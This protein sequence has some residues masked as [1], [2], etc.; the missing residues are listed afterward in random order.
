M[1]PVA[2]PGPD[3]R[4]LRRRLHQIP[5]IGLDLPLTQAV[6]L[7]ALS[8]LDLEVTTGKALSSVVAVLPSCSTVTVAVISFGSIE[9][10]SFISR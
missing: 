5:E 3:L 8:G 4:S 9:L 1:D 10:P 2:S 7:E 6:V